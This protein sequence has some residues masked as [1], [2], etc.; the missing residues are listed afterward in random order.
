VEEV[1]GS[2]ARLVKLDTFRFEHPNKAP[3]AKV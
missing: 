2:Y 1:F 3:I